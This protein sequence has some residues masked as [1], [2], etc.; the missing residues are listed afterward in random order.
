MK[1]ALFNDF[2]LGIVTGDAVVDVGDAVADVPHTGPHDL[3][4]NLI[5]RFADYRGRL[6]VLA[7]RGGGVPLASVRLRPPLPRP[8]NIVC[9]AGNYMEDGTLAEPRPMNPSSGWFNT[10]WRIFSFAGS[11]KGFGYA[12]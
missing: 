8:A 9:M 11:G 6:E 1:L 3:I 5:E 2:R 4:S 7:S 10:D 12:V